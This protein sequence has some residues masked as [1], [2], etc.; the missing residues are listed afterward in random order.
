MY[1]EA[2]GDSRFS[3]L[4]KGR[5]AIVIARDQSEEWQRFVTI[6]ELMHVFDQPLARVGTPEDFSS[7]VDGLTSPPSGDVSDALLSEGLALFMA[8]GVVCQELRRQGFVR[9]VK[10]GE[11]TAAQV[12]HELR[13]PVPYVHHLL[14][15]HFK[16]TIR[17]IL[18]RDD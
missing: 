2:G 13:I 16:P 6:K 1:L 10:S 4:A 11:L 12:A 5:P 8:L 14:G 18:D 9:R 7:L 3:R 17:F 15:A